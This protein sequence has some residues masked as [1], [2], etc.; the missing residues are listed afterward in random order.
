MNNYKQWNNEKES[1]DLKTI[2]HEPNVFD[3][4]FPHSSYD[5]LHHKIS[6]CI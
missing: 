3:D 2:I 4:L 1:D 5:L 6:K